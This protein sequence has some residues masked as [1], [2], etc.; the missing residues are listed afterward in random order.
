M[1]MENKFVLDTLAFDAFHDED[2]ILEF[3]TSLPE[4]TRRVIF[5]SLDKS[6]GEDIV[7]YARNET[8]PEIHLVIMKFLEPDGGLSM[9]LSRNEANIYSY[10]ERLKEE[11]P[12]HSNF[13]NQKLNTLH[14]HMKSSKLKI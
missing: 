10:F 11:N 9:L 6:V 4:V 7:L 8:Q 1:N 13:I 3:I 12:K 14:E 2:D 5:D